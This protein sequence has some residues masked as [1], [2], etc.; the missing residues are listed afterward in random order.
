MLKTDTFFRFLVFVSKQDL[1]K[2][3]LSVQIEEKRIRTALDKQRRVE[4][5]RKEEERV[6]REQAEIKLQYQM[7]HRAQMK[8]EGKAN[9]NK[10]Q[11][12]SVIKA[13]CLFFFFVSAH[14]NPENNQPQRLTLSCFL[15]FI[16][17]FFF[18]K[19]QPPQLHIFSSFFQQQLI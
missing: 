12:F 5:E 13:V 18:T 11:F 7:E 8:K 9:E 2:S 14:T 10:N 1:L 3:A 17:T 6:K 16:F 19:T 4:M 15:F